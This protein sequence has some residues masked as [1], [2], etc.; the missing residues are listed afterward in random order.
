MN[1]RKLLNQFLQRHQLF[2]NSESTMIHRYTYREIELVN[3][4]NRLGR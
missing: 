2:I 3:I 4:I 1:I